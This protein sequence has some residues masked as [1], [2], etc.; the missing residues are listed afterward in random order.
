EQEQTKIESKQK[1]IATPALTDRAPVEKQTQRPQWRSQN[2]RT[3]IRAGHCKGGNA[4]HQQDGEDCVPRTDNAAPKDEHR[5]IGQNNA[6]LRQ[7]IKA[8]APGYPESYLAQPKGQRRSEIAAE[9][10]FAAN[11]EQ[12]RHVARRSAVKDRWNQRPKRG[13]RQ[14]S[15][16]EHYRR[17]SA[18]KF[19]KQGDVMHWPARG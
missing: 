11:C 15:G 12:Q 2:R 4:D 6:G 19:N 17:A 18:Q 5:P 9:H 1:P 13:L 14:R 3:K 7:R 10:E 16:P 8:E